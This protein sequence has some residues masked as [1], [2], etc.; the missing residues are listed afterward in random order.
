[1]FPIF[2]DRTRRLICRSMFLLFG[3]LPTGAVLAWSVVLNGDGHHHTICQQ[4]AA[5]LGCDVRADRVTHPRKESTLLEGFE[6]VDP[7]TKEVLF[8]SPRVEIREGAQLTISA[9]QPELKFTKN[10]SCWS[11][12]DRRL[13]LGAPSQRS[14]QFEAK[15]AM[16][17]WPEGKQLVSDCSVEINADDEGNF[18]IAKLN[19]GEQPSSEPVWLELRRIKSGDRPISLFKLQT[20]AASLPC[21]LLAVALDQKNRFGVESMFRGTLTANETEAGWDATITDS[22]FAE[23]D[24]NVLA[25]DYFPGNCTVRAEIQLGQA[26]I[27][28]GRIAEVQGT[29]TTGPGTINQLR[30]DALEKSLVAWKAQNI[31][32]EEIQFEQL[33]VEFKIDDAGTHI[34]GKCKGP[35]PNVILRAA[36]GPILGEPTAPLPRARLW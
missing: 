7:E 2:R 27:H 26:A 29:L 15:G 17:Y 8:N 5:S 3:V 28:R 11:V 16:I 14:L 23:V 18:A 4:L 19:W 24:L 13:R 25:N 20:G 35:Y 22:V 32:S 1:M 31:S 36:G 6:L 30:L 34:V 12:I 9:L 21:T 33:A 10:R